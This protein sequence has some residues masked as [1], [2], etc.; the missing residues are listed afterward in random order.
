MSTQKRLDVNSGTQFVDVTCLVDSTGVPYTAGAATGGALE[1]GGHL[2]SIDSLLT[3]VFSTVNTSVTP[4]AANGVFTG[5]AED[6]TK[7]AEVRISIYTDVASATDGLQIQQS[8]DGVNWDTSDVYSI[9][10]ATNKT[11]GVGAVQQFFRIVYTNGATIQATFRLSVK[12]NVTITKPSSVR[13]QDGRSNENDFEEIATY[14]SH[15]NGTTW[16]RMRGNTVAQFIH[17][18]AAHSAASTG[19]PVPAGGVVK[20]TSDTTLV[21][22][23]VSNLQ[24]TSSGAQTVKPYQVPELDWTFASVAGGITTTADT[25]LQTASGA[26]IRNYLTAISIVNASATISSEVVIKDGS[27]VIWRGFLG[28]GSLLNSAVG[29]TFPTPLRSTANA[30]LNVAAITTAS[31]I[32]VNAQGYKAP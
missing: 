2:A 10:A 11:F 13:T 22:G 19:F 32:Y 15:F 7:Y 27:T 3:T 12:L 5:T 14:N 17:G 30:A 16:D 1:T 4:L 29:V 8:K 25:V 24:I 6:I 21:D 28:V 31:Q 26:G 20:T 9:P 18:P 23:D